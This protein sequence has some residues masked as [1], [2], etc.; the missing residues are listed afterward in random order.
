MHQL[1]SRDVF[2][3]ELTFLQGKQLT[4]ADFPALA[5]VDLGLVA[6]SVFLRLA[7]HL[8][9]QQMLVHQ[10]RSQFNGLDEGQDRLDA[11]FS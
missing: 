11:D 8:I 6:V 2:L 1:S 4:I 9:S 3:I 7:W 10:S 5:Q